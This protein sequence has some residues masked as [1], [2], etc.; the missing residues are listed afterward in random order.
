MCGLYS[1]FFLAVYTT[2][3]FEG[4]KLTLVGTETRN[5]VHR[6]EMRPF[7]KGCKGRTLL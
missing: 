3:I 2:S 5:H 1:K 4:R 7:G 6:R